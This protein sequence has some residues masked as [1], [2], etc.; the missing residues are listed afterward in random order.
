MNTKGLIIFQKNPVLGK[1]KTRL[2]K[3]IGDEAALSVY[4]A[5]VD[6]TK[7]NAK[8]F[9]AQILVYYSDFIPDLEAE[10]YWVQRIQKG[11][12]LGERMRGAFQD[13][14]GSGMEKV[15]IIGTDCP[16]VTVE[17]L[18]LASRK[19]DS[20]DVVIGPAID[21]GYYLLGMRKFCPELFDQIAWSTDQVLAQT[22]E[23][24]QKH[25]LSVSFLPEFYD[26][27][28]I[29]ELNK[30]VSQYPEYAYLSES[31]VTKK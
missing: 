8:T 24:A 10:D 3:T 21:G 28:T 13:T 6:L 20:S 18:D 30:F 12:D 16:E 17:V 5:L 27:D 2:A 9:N 25:Q 26:I 19:L 23:V 4:Q 31:E 15:L 1:V 22:I 29:D 14:F 11:K 7:A